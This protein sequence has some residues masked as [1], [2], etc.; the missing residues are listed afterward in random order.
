MFFLKED[1]FTVFVKND[2]A[3]LCACI[4]IY[5]MVYLNYQR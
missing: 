4:C 5:G 1:Y 3:G 2:N